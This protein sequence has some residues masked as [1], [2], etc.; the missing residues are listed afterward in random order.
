MGQFGVAKFR[1]DFLFVKMQMRYIIR[2][3]AIRQL[4][5]I[6]E[7]IMIEPFS[8]GVPAV[9]VPFILWYTSRPKLSKVDVRGEVSI[10]C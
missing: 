3:S 2:L 9:D 10:I 5:V 7:F 1:F 6:S 4:S 8:V